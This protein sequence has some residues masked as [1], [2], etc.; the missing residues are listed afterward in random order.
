[1]SRALVFL[2]THVAVGLGRPTAIQSEEWVFFRHADVRAAWLTGTTSIDADL[3]L[4]VDDE[5]WENPEDPAQAFVQPP[6]K[7]SRASMFVWNIKLARVMSYAMKTIASP[8][9]CVPRFFGSRTPPVLDQALDRGPRRGARAAA[10][11]R[12]RLVHERVGRVRPGPP[13]VPGPC[14]PLR[15]ARLTRGAVRWDAARADLA[16]LDQSAALWTGFYQL[17]LLVH[18][19]AAACGGGAARAIVLHAAR[20][21]ARIAAAHQRRKGGLAPAQI[22]RAR[23]GCMGRRRR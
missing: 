7:P 17:Q 10:R 15:Q 14:P 5:Y 19:P 3:P 9:N 23:V 6:G 4:E 18:R 12:A 21:S 20:A 2:D 11:R 8:S 22:V 13:C 1:M 16:F